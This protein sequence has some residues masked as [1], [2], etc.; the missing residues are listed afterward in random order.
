MRRILVVTNMWP[1]DEKFY[2][3]LFVKEQVDSIK[4]IRSQWEVDVFNIKGY[5]R[6]S[7]Y[8]TSIFMIKRLL[9]IKKYDLIHIHFGLSGLFLLV[10]NNIKLPVICTFHGSDISPNS[11]K[12]VIKRISMMVARRCSRL[13]VLNESMVNTVSTLKVSFDVVP[14]GVNCDYFINRERELSDSKKIRIGF[15]SSPNRPEKNYSLFQ[16]IVNGLKR[17]LKVE[18]EVIF[19]MD[20]TRAQVLE[21]LCEIDVL[22][23]T[24]NYEGSPQIIKEA[25]A[26]N[27]K[28]VTRDVGDV[29]WLLGNVQ[30]AAVIEFDADEGE[31]VRSIILLLNNQVSNIGRSSRDKLFDL[32]LDHSTVASRL[33]G[34]YEEEMNSF[35][36]KN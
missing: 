8:I 7:S 30:N 10:L 18:V 14:C 28:I 16:K 25:M 15:P 13:L 1:N 5:A 12:S 11:Q 23:M 19:F 35:Y 6:K 22:L 24:S 32:G 26:C 34:I 17:E 3:G 4:A 21:N 29:R 20:L 36:E 2:Y 27:T 9:K 33:I 31:Y